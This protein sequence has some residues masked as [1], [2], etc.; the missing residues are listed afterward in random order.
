V[1]ASLILA[2]LVTTVV[3][4]VVVMGFRS[5][6]PSSLRATYAR[7]VTALLTSAHNSAVTTDVLTEAE[8]AHLPAAVRRYIR[9][10]GAVGQPHIRNVRAEVRGRI[11]SGPEAGWMS[12]TGEQHNFFDQPARLFYIDAKMFAVPTQ[13]FHRY[14][15]PS[16]T[17]RVT[18]AWTYPMVNAAGPEM[19]VSETVTLFN[20]MCWI[21]AGTLVSDQIT[22]EE[23]DSLRV[24][25]TFTN[26]GHSIGAT[27]V[28]NEVGELIDFVSDDRL[29]ASRDGTS[30]TP[31]RWSTPLGEYR[32]FGARRISALGEAR[33]HAPE[34]V[35]P[36]IELELVD[37][38]FN[39]VPPP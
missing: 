18:I 35:Y 25:A 36:Y 11:R 26:A 38:A 13:V 1:K 2:A 15:G 34:G 32:R 21:A 29:A 31:M 7:E 24:R 9:L 23:L 20:D 33:W 28:F 12:F 8:L 39:V 3:L 37:V 17:M 5:R 30:F 16:A 4:A 22:W 10:S 14:V 6:S 27:L 19:D